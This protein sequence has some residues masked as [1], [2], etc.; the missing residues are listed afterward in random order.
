MKIAVVASNGKASRAIVAELI[1]RGAYIGEHVSL[2][3]A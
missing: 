3:Q 1:E 2:V